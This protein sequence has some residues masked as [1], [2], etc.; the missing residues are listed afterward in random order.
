YPL[1]DKKDHSCKLHR[2]A[3][4]E[5]SQWLTASQLRQTQWQLLQ[6]MLQYAQTHSPYYKRIFSEHGVDSTSINSAQDFARIPITTKDDIRK[7]HA[8]FLSDEFT[9]D[10]LVRAK[11]GGST[12]VSLE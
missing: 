2:L 6:S 3:E 1:W 12:G 9:R 5:R 7:Y 8:E 10:K 11:T 4:L